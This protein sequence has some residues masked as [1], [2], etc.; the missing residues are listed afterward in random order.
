[1]S[2]TIPFPIENRLLAALPRDEYDRLLSVSE[3]VRLPKNRI[4]YEAGDTIYHAYFLNSGMASLLAITED[5]RSI[6]LGVIGNAGFVGVPLIHESDSASYRVMLQTSATALRIE[7]ELLRVELDRSTAMRRLLSRYAHGHETQLV[8]GVVCNLYHSVE[9]RLSRR[10]LVTSDYLRSEAL[11]LTQEHLG[12]VLDRNRTRVSI[13]AGVL[14]GNGLIEYDRRG[15]IT[16]LNREG[17]E[18]SACDCY[19]IIKEAVN[20]VC[21]SP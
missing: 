1:M 12:I 20:Q 5:G 7:A 14:H 8:K 6:E 19:R 16:I 17:L 15:R 10:L 2:T 21:I 11:A 18:L 4:L 13:A 3:L 9:Q